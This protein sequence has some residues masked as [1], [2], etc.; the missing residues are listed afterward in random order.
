MTQHFGGQII[1]VRVIGQSHQKIAHKNS[2]LAQNL[3]Q[4]MWHNSGK[5]VQKLSVLL[6]KFDHDK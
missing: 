5:I 1:Y 2:K 3:L 4:K 6:Y